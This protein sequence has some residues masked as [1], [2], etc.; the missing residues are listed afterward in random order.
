MPSKKIKP[1]PSKRTTS[2]KTPVVKTRKVSSEPKATSPVNEISSKVFDLKKKGLLDFKKRLPNVKVKKTYI[3]LGLIIITLVGLIVYYRRVFIVAIVNGQPITRL[4]YINEAEGVYLQDQRV[5]AGKQ[6]LN[7][8]VTKT[9]LEQEAA[10]RNISVSDKEVQDEVAKTRK[11]LEEQKQKLEDALALQGDSLSAYESR[12][13]TQKLIQKLI[14]KVAVTEKEVEDYI[15]QN[16]ASLQGL[17]GDDLKNQVKQTLESQKSSEKLQTLIQD[18][19][20]KAKVTY[21]ISK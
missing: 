20:K 19:Q 5:T 8:L 15:K 7:Q 4:A 21:F 11:M 16:E 17:S 12:I 14:G 2:P 1:A 3:I 13:R 10:K 9:L 6:A 18:L